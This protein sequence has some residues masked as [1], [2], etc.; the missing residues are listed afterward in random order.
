MGNARAKST[1]AQV[2]ETSGEEVAGVI[3]TTDVAR[4]RHSRTSSVRTKLMIDGGAGNGGTDAAK[5]QNET[6]ESHIVLA[7][8]FQTSSFS[9]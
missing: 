9:G 5:T 6:V 3:Q 4:M 7:S 8:G 2:I 1:L